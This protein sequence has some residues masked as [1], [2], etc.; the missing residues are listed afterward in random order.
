MAGVLII[1]V[2]GHPDI[3]EAT[4]A[5][6]ALGTGLWVPMHAGLVVAVIL[7]LVGLLG[8]YAGHADRLGRVGAV[9]FALAVPG[10]VLAACAFYWEAFLLPVIA[11]HAP[12]TFAWN[13]PVVGSWAVVA[14]GSLAALWFIGLAL[15]G[16]ALWRS[17][18]VPAGAALTLAVGAVAFA[19]LAGPF[20][21]VLGPLSV[22]AFAA[23]HVWVGAALRAGAARQAADPRPGRRGPSDEVPRQPG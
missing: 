8:L 1:P 7:S 21:P 12:G 5:H 20:V 11:R 4:L 18:L 10:L 22:V 9:G 3:F 16:L 23:G 6:A 14:S 19:L 15:L 2:V 17:G 13:G